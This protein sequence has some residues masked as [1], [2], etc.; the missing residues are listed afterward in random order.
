MIT[1]GVNAEVLLCVGQFN[2]LRMMPPDPR[3]QEMVSN[4]RIESTVKK[5]SLRPSNERL[6]KAPDRNMPVPGGIALDQPA[7][8]SSTFRD[9]HSLDSNRRSQHEN[10]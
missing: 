7:V 5:L 4:Y 2:E 1:G 8:S 6:G 9:R 10:H 3:R